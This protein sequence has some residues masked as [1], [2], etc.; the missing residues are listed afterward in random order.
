MNASEKVQVTSIETAGMIALQTKSHTLSESIILPTCRKMVKTMLG[1]EAE[2]EI[3]KNPL[4][5]NTIHRRIMDLPADIEGNVQNKLQNSEFAQ[6]ADES[7]DINNK[8]Q[9]LTFIRFIDGNQ[10]INQFFCCEEMPLTTRGQDIF[11]ILS[12]YLEKWNLSWN[13]R[14]GIC[15]D[16][17]PSM[18]SSIKGFVSLI[19]QKT[20]NVIR[21]HFFLHREVLVSKTI[22]DELKQVLNQVF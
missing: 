18:I 7:T 10:I 8:V 21:T 20:P 1:D 17:A 19:Q 13:S 9:L 2:Q 11:D 5:N 14:V 6:Q 4:S 22:P 3:S 12:A 15:T 16:G